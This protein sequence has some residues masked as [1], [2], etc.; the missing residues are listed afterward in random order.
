MTQQ[1]ILENLSSKEY[2][3]PAD[4]EARKK[5]EGVP[6]LATLARKFH[7]IGVDRILLL[8][9]MASKIRVTKFQFPGLYRLFRETQ[10]ILDIN[11]NVD[12]Y[13]VQSFELNA[14][15]AGVEYPHVTITTELINHLTEEELQYI[16][17]HELGHIQSEHV[18]YHEIGRHLPAIGTLIGSATLGLG[19]LVGTGLEFAL[20][21]WIRKSEFTADRAGLLACQDPNVAKRTFCKLAG[22]PS[23][24]YAEVNFA[25]IERQVQEFEAL[26]NTDYNRLYSQYAQLLNTHPWIVIRMGDLMRWMDGG[27]YQNILGRR[28]RAVPMGT[29]RCSCGEIIPDGFYFCIG[30][31]QVVR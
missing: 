25:E 27:A 30:C 26:L 29:Q 14:Y 17:G 10:E 21:D 16:L 31:G 28:H 6:G 15:A 7:E 4:G 2:S 12:L 20:Y 24:W 8:Q 22:V 1:V 5:L 11:Y 19:K 9:S 3:H 23:N 13:I 18:L